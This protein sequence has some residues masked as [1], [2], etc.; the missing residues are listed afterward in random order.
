MMFGHYKKN[1]NVR[2]AIE[3]ADTEKVNEITF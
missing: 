3:G 2:M 1:K